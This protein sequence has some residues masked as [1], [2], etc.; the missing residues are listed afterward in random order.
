MHNAHMGIDLRPDPAKRLVEARTRRGFETAKAAAN[1]FG[2]KYQTYAQHEQ[3]ERGLT[4][5]AKKYARA[6]RVGE[7][8]LLTGEGL[9]PGESAVVP[10]V[11][12]VSAGHLRDQP[13]VTAADVEDWRDFG[14]LARGGD[15]I[16]LTVQGRSMDMVA[17]DGAIILVNR[18]D[19]ELR[20][21]GLYVFAI[22]DGEATFKQWQ[23]DPPRLQPL[24]SDRT[25]G[26]IP[27][28]SLPDLFVVGRVRTIICEA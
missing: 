14:D 6:Y 2:W 5:A 17:P 27:A 11:S 8:W 23:P 10:V 20:P 3:G 19:T 15:W 25:I 1:Y 24:S 28:D 26:S 7:G 18:A 9:G 13:A 12:M 22:G 21:G 4:R 16:A